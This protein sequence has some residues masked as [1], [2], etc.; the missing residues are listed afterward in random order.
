M[1]PLYRVGSPAPWGS[2]PVFSRSGVCSATMGVTR[3]NDELLVGE[4]LVAHHNNVPVYLE[5]KA[6]GQLHTSKASTI[7][8][9]TGAM[10]SAKG[11][12]RMSF[13]SGW[14]K[15]Q[16]QGVDRKKSVKNEIATKHR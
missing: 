4:E 12:V 6:G 3:S 14:K 2:L 7:W 13:V 15:E 11:D 5:T 1:G 10:V 8:R 16:S 9:C